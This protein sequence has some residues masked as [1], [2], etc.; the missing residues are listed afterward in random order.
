LLSLSSCQSSSA[1]NTPA[2][3]PGGTLTKTLIDYGWNNPS[4]QFV[5]DNIVQMEQKPFGGLTLR[6]APGSD[7]FNKVAYPDVDFEGDQANLRATP[8][9]SLTH[10]FVAMT[11]RLEPGWS[12]LSSADWQATERNVRNYAKTAAAG[13]FKGI[14]FDPEPYGLSPWRYSAENYGGKSF[15]EVSS[16]VR[17]R[18]RSFIR[19]VH[20]ELPGAKILSFWFLTLLKAQLEEA[21]GVLEQADYALLLPFV[22]GWFDAAQG[23]TFIDGSEGSYY[24]LSEQDFLKNRDFFRGAG[25]VLSSENQGKYTSSTRLAGAV[26]L[27][28]VLDLWRSPR[29]VGFYLS[30]A[31]ERLKLLEHNLYYGLKNSDQYLWVYGENVDWWKG[32]VPDGL[33]AALVSARDKVN[34]GQP[35]GFEVKGFVDDAR[36]E[37]DRKVD[38]GGRVTQ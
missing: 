28:G 17:E 38:I 22:E 20:A 23:E 33:E 9:K 31:D 32:K 26:Y 2:P 21:G 7:V 37:Y 36:L 35:L 30:N 25:S 10:N 14:V 18:G 24:F 11:V 27:D 13:R 12:W 15:N 1:P 8:F 3:A 4:S 34:S 5:R 6:L 19:A 16:V 29:F